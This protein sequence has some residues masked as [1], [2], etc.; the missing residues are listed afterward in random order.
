M[1][2]RA[3]LQDINWVWHGVHLPK[4]SP[5]EAGID[6]VALYCYFVQKISSE[7]VSHVI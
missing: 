2:T 3:L 4:L 1:I 6:H 5:R 7:F